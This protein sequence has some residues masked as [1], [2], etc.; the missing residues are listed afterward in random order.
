[1]QREGG[2]TQK[3]LVDKPTGKRR[4]YQNN[5]LGVSMKNCIDLAL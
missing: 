1:M 3:I 2:N 4:Q 5:D